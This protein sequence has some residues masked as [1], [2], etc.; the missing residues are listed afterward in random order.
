MNQ[1]SIKHSGYNSE[2]NVLVQTEAMKQLHKTLTISS[3]K[4]KVQ[5]SKRN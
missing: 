1:N 4:G 5:D 2:Y 3:S